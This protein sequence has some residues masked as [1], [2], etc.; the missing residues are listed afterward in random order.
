[1]IEAWEHVFNTVESAYIWRK[2]VH[3]ADLETA[4]KILATWTGL[5]AKYLRKTIREKV[6]LRAEWNKQRRSIMYALV[7]IKFRD[8]RL[9]KWLLDK[10]QSPLKECVRRRVLEYAHLYWTARTEYVR[11]HI[12]GTTSV[13]SNHQ[14]PRN[15]PGRVA[16]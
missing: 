1:M 2:R 12:Q 8:A 13:H 4:Q 11:T 5:Q 3:H 14:S 6:H 7:A 10:Q 9:H 15:V 16:S